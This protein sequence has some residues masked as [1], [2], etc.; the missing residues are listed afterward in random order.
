MD[1]LKHI[2]RKELMDDIVR[3]RSE[4]AEICIVSASCDLWLQPFADANQ[5]KLICTELQYD[6]EGNYQGKF[7]TP[8]CNGAEKAI[9]LKREFNLGKYSEVIVYGNS[10]DDNAMF[11]L[12][13][14]KKLIHD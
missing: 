5:L 6:T 4:S 12:G 2:L 11:E 13:T 9:R 7:S 8:N 10:S 1:R 3:F 14:T